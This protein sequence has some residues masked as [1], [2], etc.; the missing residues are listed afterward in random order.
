MKTGL[1]PAFCNACDGPMPESCSNL[2]LLMPAAKTTAFRAFAVW[3]LPSWIYFTF[4]ATPCLL[5]SYLHSYC[6]EEHK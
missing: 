6:I 1:M 4:L 5:N 3:T 2:L